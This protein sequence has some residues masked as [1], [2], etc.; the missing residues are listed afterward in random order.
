M[1]FYLQSAGE[2]ALQIGGAAALRVED[3]VFT[4]Y[5]EQ[6]VLMWRDFGLQVRG[7]Y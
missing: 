5:R 1:S 7:G 6:G 3:M 2:E 4:Q